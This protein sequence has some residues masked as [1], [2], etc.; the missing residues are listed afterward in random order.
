MPLKFL[1]LTIFIMTGKPPQQPS[2]PDENPNVALVDEVLCEVLQL[3]DLSSLPADELEFV[4]DQLVMELTYVEEGDLAG[5][6]KKRLTAR[7]LTYVQTPHEGEDGWACLVR[8]L[9]EYV[10]AAMLVGENARAGRLQLIERV[11]REFLGEDQPSSDDAHLEEV[12]NMVDLAVTHLTDSTPE[13]AVVRAVNEQLET[14]IRG[15]QPGE[16][17]WA[18][19]C[20]DLSEFEE[21]VRQAWQKAGVAIDAIPEGEDA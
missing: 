21:K 11:L 8:T 13:E 18:C 17:R 6:E 1:P 4:R 16:S 9:S 2:A 5:T 10:A 12:I 19:I 14:F 15:I 3:E 7:L 20:R